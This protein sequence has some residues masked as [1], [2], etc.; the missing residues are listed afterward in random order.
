MKRSLLAAAMAAAAICPALAQANLISGT[1]A[2]KETMTSEL[3]DLALDFSEALE[4]KST[5]VTIT[6][7]SGAIAI[8]SSALDP[9]DDEVLEVT[10]SAAL[11]AGTYRVA[12]HALATD[13]HKTA[14]T[15]TFTAK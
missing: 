9:N 11:P 14:G 15:Y 1:P 6:G 8:A 4:I 7:P 10:L 5:G 12:W 2:D 3:T 13:G